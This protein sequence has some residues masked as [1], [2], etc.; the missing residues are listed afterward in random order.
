MGST[1]EA[2]EILPG[3]LL[4]IVYVGFY[5]TILSPN[6]FDILMFH[7]QNGVPVSYSCLAFSIDW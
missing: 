7:E 5:V 1:Q 6:V 4:N 2:C 3:K